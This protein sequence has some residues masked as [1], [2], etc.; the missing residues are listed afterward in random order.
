[1]NEK[2]MLLLSATY[3]KKAVDGFDK[4]LP[5]AREA[6]KHFKIAYEL[7]PNNEKFKNDYFECLDRIKDIEGKKKQMEY[8]IERANALDVTIH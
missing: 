6:L 1:M 4:W 2:E 3:A 7:E 5:N 8:I